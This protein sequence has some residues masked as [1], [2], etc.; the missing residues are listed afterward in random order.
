MTQVLGTLAAV[1]GILVH[2]IGWIYALAV[3]AYALAWLP[4]ESLVAVAMRRL[5]AHESALQARHLER[6]EAPLHAR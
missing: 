5:I 6:V 4:L 3:W 1:Y 2:P